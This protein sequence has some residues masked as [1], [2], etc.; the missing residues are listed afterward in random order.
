[1]CL[2]SRFVSVF[3]T[4]LNMYEAEREIEVGVE[5]NV[6]QLIGSVVHSRSG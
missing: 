5:I 3:F 4:Y 6:L 1:M 2:K